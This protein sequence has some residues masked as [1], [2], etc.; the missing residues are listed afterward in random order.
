VTV[1]E[2]PPPGQ[3][4]GEP[5]TF[6]PN[7]YK[8]DSTTT[9][10]VQIVHKNGITETHR[11]LA[12]DGDTLQIGELDAA[13][14]ELV[15]GTQFAVTPGRGEIAAVNLE[16]KV[17]KIDTQLCIGCGLCEIECPVVGDRRA[18]YVTAEGETRSQNYQERDR[19]RSLRLMKTDASE[20]RGART[21]SLAALIAT[22]TKPAA[23][24]GSCSTAGAGKGGCC[25]GSSSGGCGCSQTPP[26][27]AAVPV[28]DLRTFLS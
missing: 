28:I 20:A 7:E 13:T 16:F 10:H 4:F 11:V 19:N 5:C 24:K 17:P 1:G 2:Y 27:Q 15:N 14:G 26:Q 18:V 12:N 21:I 9:Y 23:P 25:G 22:G 8:G 3:A 6:R